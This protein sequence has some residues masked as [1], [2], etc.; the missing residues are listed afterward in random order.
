MPMN[1]AVD[2]IE[3]NEATKF[4]VLSF[5]D[6]PE[7]MYQNAYPFLKSQSIPFTLF[8]ANEYIGKRGYLSLE[9]IKELQQTD[10]CTIGAHTKSHQMLRRSKNVHEEI[11]GCKE[12]LEELLDCSV[13][14]FAYPYGSLQA[15]DKK[16]V[17]IAKAHYRAAF[18][19][20]YADIND[21][22]SA[23]RWFLPR[24]YIK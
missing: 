3:N 8:L 11:A 1:G 20:V 15:V 13:N 5:D 18:S 2:I 4:A 23:Y 7:D 10:L 9:Q 24:K 16:S 17:Y 19:T 6:V 22:S 12:E 14:Y 21:T